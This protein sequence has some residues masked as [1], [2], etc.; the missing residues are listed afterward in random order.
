MA[1]MTVRLSAG[2]YDPASNSTTVSATV[3]VTWDTSASYDQTNGTG[4]LTIGDSYSTY[5]STN[6]NASRTSSGTQVLG[7]GSTTIYHNS[8][9]DPVQVTANASSSRFNASDI[10]TLPGGTPSGSSGGNSGGSSGGTSGGS[11]GGSSST[12][13]HQISI[14]KSNHVNLDIRRTDDNTIVSNGSILPY[15]TQISMTFSADEGYELSASIAYGTLE[16]TIDVS[17]GSYEFIF[18]QNTTIVFTATPT[19]AVQKPVKYT[20]CT[21]GS[22]YQSNPVYGYNTGVTTIDGHEWTVSSDEPVV[23]GTGGYYDE[24]YSAMLSFTTP[25]VERMTGTIHIEVDAGTTLYSGSTVPVRYALCTSDSTK[26]LYFGTQAYVFDTEQISVGM[27]R[28]PATSL[29]RQVVSFDIQAD[30]LQPDTTYYLYFWSGNGNRNDPYAFAKAYLYYETHF[31]ITVESLLGDTAY[32][33]NGTEMLR[34]QYY[35]DNG[36]G[37]VTY[38]AYIDT[39]TS[40]ELYS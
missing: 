25:K 10:I 3:S 16:R 5:F 18:T 14:I 4:T 34:Y 31:V 27:L 13:T 28:L 9:G 24:L 26:K 1:Y 17:S 19:S 39:G 36:S 20:D 21:V 38:A 8:N 11:S 30:G 15:Y 29:D 35:I 22:W 7:G 33:D 12:E 6:F 23:A 40:W 32:I 37:W 2:S